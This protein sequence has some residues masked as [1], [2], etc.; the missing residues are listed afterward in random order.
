VS[1]YLSD[2]YV[3]LRVYCLGRVQSSKDALKKIGLKAIRP[4]TWGMPFGD[5][6]RGIYGA[7]PPELLHQYDLGIIKHAYK[8]MLAVIKQ[9]RSCCCFGMKCSY[10][11]TWLM[12]MLVTECEGSDF[13]Y[14]NRMNELDIRLMRFNV[15]HSAFDMPRVRFSNGA[16]SIAMMK[17]FEFAPLLWQMIVVLG[18]D[19]GTSI[20]SVPWKHKMVYCFTLLLQVRHLLRAKVHTERSLA[21]L[22]QLIPR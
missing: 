12:C 3:W 14:T 18:V 6:P 7:T 13:A 9:G 2:L 8:C 17:A 5:N 22:K 19:G 21:Q 4:A 16:S 20:V 1:T 15:R 10:L 11:R